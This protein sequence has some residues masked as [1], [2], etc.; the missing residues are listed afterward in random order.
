MCPHHSR[1]HFNHRVQ[2]LTFK[3]LLY[4]KADFYFRPPKASRKYACIFSKMFCI[5]LSK[6]PRSSSL[7]MVEAD[8]EEEVETLLETSCHHH[9]QSPS[10]LSPLSNFS[11]VMSFSSPQ[12]VDRSHQCLE[13]LPSELLRF[14]NCQ[15]K[16]LN[17]SSNNLK[18][19]P[20][21]F[22]NLVKLTRL[23][24]SDNQLVR[25]SSEI[26][27]FSQLEH[28]NVS[29]NNLIILPE[30]I[31]SLDNLKTMDLSYNCLTSLPNGIV[32]VSSLQSLVLNNLF[33]KDL[34]EDIGLLRNLAV[35]EVR[36][37]FLGSIPNSLQDLENLK[38]L[39]LGNNQIHTVVD[40]TSALQ[41]LRN[42]YR[43]SGNFLFL[44]A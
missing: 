16:D 40:F 19:L 33:L 2:I 9:Q 15:M 10:A 14:S 35:L 1:P 18:T 28:L 43:L 21:N 17:L 6:L 31:K 37:N 38:R 23:D 34:P 4:I 11:R 42:P 5:R 30:N 8:T 13:K 39:D 36:D 25:L 24:L 7:E 20:T 26:E 44:L 3:I 29:R 41:T 27:L 12:S 22:Y 32:L